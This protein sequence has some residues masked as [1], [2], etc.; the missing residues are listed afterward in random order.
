M[1]KP[2]I[3]LMG[4]TYSEVAGVTLPT[5]GGTSA[6]FPWVEGSETVT[7]NGT[8][9]VTNLAELVVNVAG[10]GGASNIVTGT[11]KYSTTSAAAQTVTLN[12]TGSGY[13][14]AAIIVLDDGV[15]D[16]TYTDT[17]ARYS[18]AQYFMTKTYMDQTPTYST[19]GNANQGAVATVYK[20][21]ASTAATLTRTSSATV[22]TFSSSNATGS[23]TT[24]VRFK[25]RTS[26]SIYSGANSGTS[27]YG[28]F[29]GLQYRYW[30]IYSS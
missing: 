15:L 7:Q 19:S 23:T 10:G 2:N 13:P 18:I 8:V 14:I 26:M 20:S 6:T 24:C 5:S 16:T 3:R 22:N 17:V 12:Y 4:A 28:F 9:D 1:A 25:S 30:I 11:F 21:S 27:R 29:S